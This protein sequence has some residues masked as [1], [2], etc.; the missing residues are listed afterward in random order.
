MKIIAECGVNWKN[1]EEA[2]LMIRKSKEV[3]CWATKFQLYNEEVIRNHKYYKFLK[4]IML[5]FDIAKELFDYGKSINQEVFFSCMF[6]EAVDWCEDVGVKYYKIRFKDRNNFNIIDKI[7]DTCKPYF[8]SVGY[9]EYNLG[10]DEISLFCIPK[11]PTTVYDYIKEIWDILFYKGISDHTSTTEL[12]YF[13]LEHNF[14]YF[15]KHVKLTEDCIESAWSV[16]FEELA[17]VLK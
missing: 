5:D 6:P 3:G 7:K 10:I 12:I 17:E 2:K 8:R 14:E 1:L 11:Y 15:E 4:S 13:A 16:T 9:K